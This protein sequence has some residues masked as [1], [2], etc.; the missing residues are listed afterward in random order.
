MN[1]QNIL[2]INRHDSAHDVRAVAKSAT[3]EP[4]PTFQALLAPEKYFWELPP[5]CVHVL[6]R[7]SMMSNSQS[8]LGE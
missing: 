8:T 5:A 1:I 4:S 7:E 2:C 6:P 3:T